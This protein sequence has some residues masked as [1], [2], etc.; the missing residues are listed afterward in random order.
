M[1]SPSNQS[2]EKTSH[3]QSMPRTR[4]AEF[5]KFARS[6]SNPRKHKSP[7][8]KR[9]APSLSTTL[10][11]TLPHSHPLSWHPGSRDLI[12]QMSRMVPQEVGKG[13]TTSKNNSEDNEPA[14]SDESNEATS[15]TPLSLSSSLSL[16]DNNHIHT[17]TEL[18][19][20]PCIQQ[21]KNSLKDSP[22]PSTLLLHFEGA[23]A[24]L[25]TQR[26]V[27]PTELQ[28]TQAF[29]PPP[30]FS[31]IVAG[32]HPQDQTALLKDPLIKARYIDKYY[33]D[34]GSSPPPSLFF[35][36]I[37]SIVEKPNDYCQTLA[38]ATRAID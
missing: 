35:S 16:Q 9:T 24:T 14:T 38:D 18:P 21:R 4:R 2:E 15:L 34:L 22:S 3:G 8:D 11:P 17:N 27:L 13:K 33:W 1:H 32:Y 23:G 10:P 19:P 36:Q 20:D 7:F 6:L 28:S 26:V 30:P 29:P 5:L 12:R 31:T 37:R 25:K